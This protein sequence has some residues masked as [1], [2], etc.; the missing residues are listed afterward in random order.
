MDG[1]LQKSVFPGDHKLTNRGDEIREAYAF[2]EFRPFNFFLYEI[3]MNQS[4]F[5]ANNLTLR[6][7]N[8]L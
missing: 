4:C 2:V 8:I 7:Y 1:T 3:L 5:S 6:L